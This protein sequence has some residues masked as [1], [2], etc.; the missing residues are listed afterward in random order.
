MKAFIHT[1]YGVIEA[2]KLVEI[3]KPKPR[4]N[5]VLIKVEATSVNRT[6]CAMLN[7]YPFVWR[8]YMGLFKPKDCKLGTEFSGKV[9]D[10]GKEVELFKVGDK[11]YGLHDQG[12]GSH[13]E[14]I[15]LPEEMAITNIPEN[16]SYKQAAVSS[17]GAHYAY[18]VVNKVNITKGQKILINGASGGIGS[19]ALQLVKNLNAEVTAVC[20]TKNIDLM[21]SLGADKTIDYTKEDFTKDNEKYD[22]VFDTVGKSTFSKCKALLNPGGIYVSSELGPW[23]QNVFFALFTPITC[24]LPWKKGKKVIFPIP[25]D[26]KGS[27]AYIKNLM[28][29]GKYKAVIDKEYPFEKIPEAFKYVNQGLKTGNVVITIT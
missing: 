18:N 27:L 19:A 7:A 29:Q 3:D 26:M 20:D 13:A 9:V 5:E 14:Y 28:E 23:M 22:Y 15:S 17:E 10:I 11:V 8:F 25:V 6:D 1:K 16:T 24:K 21:K 4:N 12:L 2:L